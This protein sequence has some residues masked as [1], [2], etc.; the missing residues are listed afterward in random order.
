MGCWNGTCAVSNLHVTAGQRVM[1]LMLLKNAEA[2]SFCYGNAL[3]D[4]CPV[5]FYGKYNDYGAVEDCEGFGLNLVVDALR[6]QLYEF[7]QGPNS[8]HDCVVNQSN[9][10]LDLLFEADHEDRLGIQENHRWSSDSYDLGELQRQKEE[11]NGLSPEQNFELDRLANKIKKVDTFRQVTHIIIHSDILDAIL[12]KWYIEDYVGDGK[13]TTGYGKNYNH[14]YFKDLMDS[15]P[16]YMR[17]VKEKSSEMKKSV[18]RLKDSS[19]TAEQISEY[20]SAIF[21]ISHQGAFEWDDPCMAGKWMN[22]FKRSE[23]NGWALI[24]VGEYVREYTEAEDWDGLEAFTKEV[25]T[26]AWIN[27][28]MSYSRKIWT[29]QSGK[30][31]QNNEHLTYEILANAIL[32]VV[33]AEKAEYEDEEE[34]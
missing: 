26:T 24:D 7:G 14:L 16:E 6:S 5:P 34:E 28:F 22:Y 4:I 11:K 31:S 30:G 29:K 17:R 21:Y 27:S 1:V 9:F 13:G 23:S 20:R 10:D 32:D 25:L 3:Y 12:T 15:V 8:A 33:K 2:R 19:L 18:E